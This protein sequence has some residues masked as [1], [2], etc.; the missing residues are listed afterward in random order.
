[1]EF[2]IPAVLQFKRRMNCSVRVSRPRIMKASG[3]IILLAG[4]LFSGCKKS[5]TDAG[6]K[7]NTTG[8][9]LTAP[10]DYLG[11]VGK[12]HQTA[13][14]VVDTVGLK[15]AIGQF[16]AMEGRFPKDLK[17][18]VTQ[19]YLASIPQPPAGKKITYNPTTGDVKIE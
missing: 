12:A 5:D 10:A 17:E 18:L 15:Q 13:T 4:L 2:D 11:A 19:K 9:P 7:T 6:Q 8:N 14:K 16:Y 1:M 3:L